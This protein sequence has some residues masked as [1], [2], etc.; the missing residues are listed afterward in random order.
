MIEATEEIGLGGGDTGEGLELEIAQIKQKQGAAASQGHHGIDIFS[1]G[2]VP[3]DEGEVG[4]RMAFVLP[5]E[6]DFPSSFRCAAPG[7][8]KEVFERVR[9]AK[10]CTV[11]NIHSRESGKESLLTHGVIRL[12]LRKGHLD[13]LLEKRQRPT[14][15]ALMNRFGGHLDWLG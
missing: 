9:Q 11:G 5:D 15:H 4:K 14:S 6:L 13:H 3:G 7:S 12:E 10:P 2:D 8:R 1:I